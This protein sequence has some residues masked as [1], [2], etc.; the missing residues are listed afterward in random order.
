M[1]DERL[2]DLVMKDDESLPGVLGSTH[3]NSTAVNA[4][5]R[6]FMSCTPLEKLDKREKYERALLG[7]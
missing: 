2:Q 6:R 5:E 4:L 3:L 7:S 1:N